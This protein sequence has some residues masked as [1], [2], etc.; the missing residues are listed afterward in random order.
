[1]VFV[2]VIINGSGF[3]KSVNKYGEKIV[4]TTKQPFNLHIICIPFVF[5]LIKLYFAQLFT[6]YLCKL[7]IYYVSPKQNNQPTNVN[8][9]CWNEIR[10][11]L[12]RS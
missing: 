6:D 3:N 5:F 4:D 12:A 8:I 2:H 11:P 10:P 7:Y 1:M 9:L